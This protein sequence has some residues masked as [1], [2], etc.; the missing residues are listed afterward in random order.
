MISEKAL[1]MPNARFKEFERAARE[2]DKSRE[3]RRNTRN[4]RRS[5]WARLIALFL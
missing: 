1:R 4:Q 5:A 2:Y 3:A